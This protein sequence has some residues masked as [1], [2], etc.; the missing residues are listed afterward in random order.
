MQE[1]TIS[2]SGYVNHR[3]RQRERILNHAETL[4]FAQGIK[5]V[6]V[7]D[8]AVAA[9]VTRATIYRYYAHRLAIVWALHQR[10]EAIKLAMMPAEV[11]DVQLDSTV[12][13]HRWLEVTKEY[14]FAHKLHVKFRIQ[15]D[16]L[17]TGVPEFETIRQTKR[18]GLDDSDLLIQIIKNISNDDVNISLQNRY[19]TLIT[20]LNGFEQKL[21]FDSEQLTAEFGY[22]VRQ[23]YETFCQ[24][25]LCGVRN[26]SR[27]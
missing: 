19:M 2:Q 9:Q 1:S 3:D 14:F 6:N 15:M 23:I 27:N 25:L 8:I 7:S 13:L 18:T 20:T 4:F 10:Y 26:K 12:R 17:Y 22:D 24:Y 21:L 11:Y 5:A 16:E